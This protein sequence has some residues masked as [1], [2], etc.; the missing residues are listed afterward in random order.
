MLVGVS[1]SREYRRNSS[2]FF[3]YIF[4]GEEGFGDWGSWSE[5]NRTCDEGAQNR[6]RVCE[7]EEISCLGAKIQTKPCLLK[8]CPGEK[9]TI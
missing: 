3:R 5:C 6:S 8:Y 9:K 1:K 2:L 7:A 4:V